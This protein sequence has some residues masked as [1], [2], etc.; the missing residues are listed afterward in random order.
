MRNF[1]VCCEFGRGVKKDVKSAAAWYHKAAER[2]DR[3]AACN[4]GYL[5]ESG[6]GVEQSWTEA[7]RWYKIAVE[8]QSPRAQHNLAWCY[9]NGKGVAKDLT[10]AVE[11][12]QAAADQGFEDASEA[13]ERLKS[14]KPERREKGSFLKG[15]FGG[16]K[17]K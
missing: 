17:S 1:G 5:Y 12:Y 16:G 8:Q 13:L 6:E 2:G 15:F 4:L 14:A 9:E 10:K 11:L 3:V 7:V